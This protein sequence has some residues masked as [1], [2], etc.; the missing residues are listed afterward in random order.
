MLRYLRQG[1]LTAALLLPISI[2]PGRAA[3]RETY[4]GKLRSGL[5]MACTPGCGLCHIDPSGGGD[6][7]P[8]GEARGASALS[9][10]IAAALQKQMPPDFDSDGMDDASELKQGFN[11]GVRGQ[12]SV[13]I[14]EYGCGA[15]LARAPGTPAPL[16]S[17]LVAGALLALRR[18]QR[19]PSPTAG[20]D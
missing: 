4:P 7:N 20:A 19:R 2:V 18:R 12:A 5:D 14:P 3:A 13:C 9:P 1:V 6:R 17:A 8:W 11:P 15:R 10:D 16:L